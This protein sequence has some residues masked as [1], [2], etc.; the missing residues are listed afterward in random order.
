MLAA[1]PWHLF[2]L[3][4]TT[5]TIDPPHA[6][7][8]KNHKAPERHELEPS[9]SQMIIGRASL[10]TNGA[11]PFR[12]LARP[13]INFDV[14]SLIANACSIIHEAGKMVTLVQD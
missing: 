2:D 4:A 13:H 12:A 3:N 14:L 9:H 1:T 8:Q 6:V 7:K 10:M 11:F 5:P